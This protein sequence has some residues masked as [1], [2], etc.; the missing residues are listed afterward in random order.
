LL[1][2]HFFCY[3]R[4]IDEISM[5]LAQFLHYVKNLTGKNMNFLLECF[6]FAYII[7]GQGNI[8]LIQ[9]YSLQLTEYFLY[10]IK[11]PYS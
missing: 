2:Q 6:T 11:Y 1:M 9:S 8:F 5:L 4:P 7:K 3:K 10:R